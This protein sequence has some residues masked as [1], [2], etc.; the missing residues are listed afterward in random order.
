MHRHRL[1]G[2]RHLP[3][4]ADCVLSAVGGGQLRHASQEQG[5]NSSR[6]APGGVVVNFKA[7]LQAAGQAGEGMQARDTRHR[8][9]LLLDIQ[10]EG[11]HG[12]CTHHTGP[13]HTD[14][15][16]LVSPS[17]RSSCGSCHCRPEHN[18]G[19]DTHVRQA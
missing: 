17:Y 8:R 13:G 18:L 1:E 7:T 2:Q 11:L 10:V 15:N 12:M 19:L 9:Q 5:S 14:C 16:V 3:L 6:E 4:D